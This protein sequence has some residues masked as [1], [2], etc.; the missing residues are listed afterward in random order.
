[1]NNSTSTPSAAW[2]TIWPSDSFPPRPTTLV[3]LG[4]VALGIIIFI[5]GL[6]YFKYSGILAPGK[7]VPIVQAIVFQLVLEGAVVAVL[8]IA[9]PRLSKMSFGQLGFEVPKLWQ[10]GVALL[11]AVAMVIVA[12]GGAQLVETLTHQKHEQQVVELFRQILGNK[13][14][15]W[16][17]AIFAIVIAP[18]MEESIFRLFVFNIGLRYGGF[19]IGSVISGLLFGAAHGDPM[20]LVPLGLGGMVLCAVYY[21][22]RNAFCSMITHGCFNALTVVALI[23]APQYAQ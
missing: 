11:G 13:S 7:P 14:L 16:F 17:F 15:A 21:R 12:D 9:L 22:T 4:A 2:P 3:A 1:V 23:V 18:F 8:L 19:W 6:A 10:I 20:V 5:A